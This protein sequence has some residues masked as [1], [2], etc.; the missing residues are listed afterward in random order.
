MRAVRKYKR[1]K[2]GTVEL[3][4]LL[5][6]LFVMIFVSLL[7]QQNPPTEA[8]KVTET[9]VV[10]EAKPSVKPVV[11]PLKI[12]SVSAVFHFFPTASNPSLP[13]GTFEMQGRFD[14]K[15][16]GLRL[17]GV[18]W[19]KRPEN[20]GMVPLF[21]TIDKSD[22]LFSGRVDFVGCKQFTLRK[23]KSIKG[24]PISGKWEGEYDCSQ[25]ATGL[26]LTIE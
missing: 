19:L 24:N 6:L 10:Q 1:T 15:T 18:R 14:E 8:P 3:T 4:S 5:D 16:R 22:S 12:Y 20:Y 17:G 13:T 25:G 26:T 9:K 21:G 2:R 7:Q 23:T 11:K